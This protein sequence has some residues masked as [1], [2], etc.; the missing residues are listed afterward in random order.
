MKNLTVAGLLTLLLSST[1]A[2]AIMQ[3]GG[4]LILDKC[5][6]DV[7][8]DVKATGNESLLGTLLTPLLT[9]IFN[10]GLKLA[11]EKLKEQAV[12]AQIDVLHKGAHFYTWRES[13]AT[14]KPQYW[15]VTGW[16]LV[17]AS[18]QTKA[19]K[20]TVAQLV[21]GYKAYTISVTGDG[22]RSLSNSLDGES[23][24]ESKLK[25]LN[26]IARTTP[27]LLAVLDVQLSSQKS[28]FRLVP[29]FVVMD[30]SIREKK[31]DTRQRDMTFE[32]AYTLPGA[33]EAVAKGL[34]KMEGLVISEL[35]EQDPMQPVIT[36]HWM[37]LPALNETERTKMTNIAAL[38]SRQKTHERS[39]TFAAAAAVALGANDWVD[40]DTNKKWE[41][42]EPDKSC[43]TLIQAKPGWLK[44]H[45]LLKSESTK[46]KPSSAVVSRW[47]NLVTYFES[48]SKSK[49]AAK[50]ITDKKTAVAALARSFDLTIAMKEFRN[51]PVSK[52]FGEILSDDSTRKDL[53]SG[54]IGAIDPATRDAKAKADAEARAILL[55]AYE[56]AILK[57]E[58]SLLAYESARPAEKATKLLQMYYDQRSANRAAE[59]LALALPYPG[60]GTW[61]GA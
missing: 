59:A 34:L 53:T 43:P 47:T 18:K 23:D 52:F 46:P 3:P 13:T 1:P 11:G 30:H 51:R 31:T 14:D 19:T 57:A 16:C 32:F 2:L 48:C 24:L 26:F 15:D 27:G 20:Q 44:A 49:S 35:R 55:K 36:S 40:P 12:E 50:E 6:G 29:R 39:A 37:P 28:E 25:E 21:K 33:A 60:A 17:V 7:A 9:G 4:I 8:G 54:I 42:V 61:L 45:A 5:P 10:S 22:D 56:D 41:P 58:G 38:R